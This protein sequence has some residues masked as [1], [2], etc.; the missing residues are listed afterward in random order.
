MH[1]RL[2]KEMVI[3]ERTIDRAK[4]NNRKNVTKHIYI[5]MEENEIR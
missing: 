4:N 2:F 1:V 3:K 5:Y